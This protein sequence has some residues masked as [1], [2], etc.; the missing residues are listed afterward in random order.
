VIAEL[1]KIHD[2]ILEQL[3]RK[4]DSW[5]YEHVLGKEYT[6]VY[7]INGLVQHDIYHLGQINVLYHQI[8]NLTREG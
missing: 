3:N 5:L 8:K 6:N 1:K 7:M 4:P 2:D